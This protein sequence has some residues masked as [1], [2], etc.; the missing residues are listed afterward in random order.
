MLMK[1][2]P[3]WS[4]YHLVAPCHISYQHFICALICRKKR[5]LNEDH[6]AEVGGNLTYINTRIDMGY[7]FSNTSNGYNKKAT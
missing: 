7:S 3:P 2:K 4:R 6:K 5:Q 1:N